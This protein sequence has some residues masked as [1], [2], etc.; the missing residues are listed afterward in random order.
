M[1]MQN[2]C[3]LKIAE[4]EHC[5]LLIAGSGLAGI[6]AAYDA[7][8]SGMSILWL[9]DGTL[10]S[11][12]SFYPLTGGLGSQVADSKEDEEVYLREVLETGCT[13]ADPMLTE[14]VIREIMG[15]VEKLPEIGITPTQK[16]CNRP[17]CFAKRERFLFGWSGWDEIRNNVR[18]IF[19]GIGN[20]KILEHCDLARLEVIGGAVRGALYLNEKEELCRVDAKAVI[21]ATGG[22]CGLYK[23]SLNTNETTG[24]GHSLALDAGASLINCEFLQFIPGFTKPVYKLLFSETTLRRAESVKNAE[25]EDALREYLESI[26]A[27]KTV[28]VRDCL[29]DRAMHGPF[30]TEDKSQYFELAM[31]KDAAEHH[32]ECGFEI[33][34]DEGIATDPNGFIAGARKMYAPYHIDLSKDKIWLAP[35]AHCCNGGIR[36]G[37]DGETRVPG[38]FAAGETAG[39][40]HGAD[41]HGGMATAAA[42]VFGARAAAGAEA[43]IK[44]VEDGQPETGRC[45]DDGKTAENLACWLSRGSREKQGSL[46]AAEVLDTLAE[47]LWYDANCF[48]NGAQLEELLAWIRSAAEAFDPLK[49][50]ETEG[51]KKSLRAFHGLRTAEALVLAM[52]ERKE[53]RGP[54]YRSDHP[55]KDPSLDGKRV[56]ITEESGQFKT[57]MTA[58]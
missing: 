4:T 31:M 16:K 32:R 6:R 3:T 28:S 49:A 35:F 19:S 24:V 22:Y 38:L 2:G 30:T 43:Y 8:K 56:I 20:V 48:R 42:L 44:A 34:F 52:L 53:S 18:E 1:E 23:H 51:L 45:E 21:L 50:A 54:H 41:R 36:I 39:G 11:G 47:K 40:I 37:R 5:D 25:G 15:Q 33:A 27:G 58:D 17:A 9:T 55:E 29:E 26:P 12:S 57:S 10:C 14:T 46:K 7:A 13:V